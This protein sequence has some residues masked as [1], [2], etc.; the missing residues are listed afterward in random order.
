[1][2]AF[3][4][5]R[6]ISLSICSLALLLVGLLIVSGGCSRHD[7]LISYAPFVT[8]TE[9]RHAAVE[10][11]V[12]TPIKITFNE[13]MDPA[14]FSP[15]SFK[16]LADSTEEKVAGTV[17]YS[18]FTVTFTPTVGFDYK[19]NYQVVLSDKVTDAEGTKMRSTYTFSFSTVIPP[20]VITSFEPTAAYNGDTVTIHGREFGNQPAANIVRIGNK[21]ALILDASETEIRF[22]VPY[23]A[24]TSL[25]KVVTSGGESESP[26]LLFALYHG[27]FWNEYASG[28][29]DNLN[30][31]C[32]IGDKYIAVGDNGTIMTSTDAINWTRQTS[33]TYFDLYG[34]D[35]TD[36]TI[37]AVGE[38]GT[39]LKSS[40]G[41]LW[42]MENWSTEVSFFDVAYGNGDFVAVGS[43]GTVIQIPMDGPMR[44]AD[45]KVFSW[46]YNIVWA[47]RRFVAVGSTGSILTSP[48]T[49]NWY[50]QGAPLRDHL[51]GV[52]WTDSL[53]V[54]VGYNGLAGTSPTGNFWTRRVPE[55]LERL[56]GVASHAART[57]AVG[58]DGVIVFSINHGINW[59]R[60]ES[61]TTSDLNEVIWDGKRFVAVGAGGTILISN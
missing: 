9:P 30:D 39:I 14:S 12:L 47:D 49:Y 24:A 32:Y 38:A 6:G 27:M 5:K 13:E 56:D 15:S 34:I 25:I 4:A 20:P 29:P 22:I 52:G 43:M 50:L 37:I 57:V 26:E 28:G 41:I 48:D 51:L 16:F 40:D 45:S 19:T 35:H 36:G 10:V 3:L 53:V 2:K 58:A 23:N 42:E 17:E 55:V 46:L 8:G 60:R 1:M 31:I 54:T 33:P 7:Y 59:A 11:P 21:S 44:A 61:P 18:G